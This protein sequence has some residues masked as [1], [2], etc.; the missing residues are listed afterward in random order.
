M[1]GDIKW[2]E[3][4]AAAINDMKPFV[5]EVFI[6]SRQP[7]IESMAF[8]NLKTYENEKFYIK[9]CVSGF[10]VVGSEYD[11]ENVKEVK[12]FET[13]YALLSEISKSYTDRFHNSLFE[14]LKCLENT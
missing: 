10:G 6:S 9:L 4:A 11:T 2:S 5:E 12:W 14:K 13:P 8:L 1:M 3:E 7:D